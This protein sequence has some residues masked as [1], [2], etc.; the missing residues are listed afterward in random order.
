MN[1]S[2]S[3]A[4]LAA[5]LGSLAAVTGPRTPS[6]RADEALAAAAA[7]VRSREQAF[8]KT[9]ADRD[10]AAF[11]GF[12]SAEAVFVGRSVLRGRDAVTLG[13]RPLFDG[14]RAPFSWQPET[15]EV[16]AS[17]TLALSR[18]PVFGPDGRRTGTF[19]ST[20]R[21]EPDGEWR[22]VLDSG[23]PPCDCQASGHPP[24]GS[25]AQ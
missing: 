7:R 5:V 24:S 14:P 4:V 21:R 18:G 20:W 17:G 10:Y 3:A 16:I 2:P 23:C 19:T 11:A 9:M 25:A 1:V 22:V 12:V 8:A 13:W 6:A 15:V